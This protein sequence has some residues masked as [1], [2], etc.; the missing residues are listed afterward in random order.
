MFLSATNLFHAHALTRSLSNSPETMLTTLALVYFPLPPPTPT[1]DPLLGGR[2]SSE[3][4][5]LVSD[6]SSQDSSLGRK[7]DEPKPAISVEDLDYVAMDRGGPSF[8]DET[9]VPYIDPITNPL[10]FVR[11][12]P[13]RSSSPVSVFVCDLPPSCSGS[14]SVQSICSD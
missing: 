7:E 11:A 13:W 12:S 6:P 1:S 3:S 4:I 10:V 8:D 2:R 9:Y 14:T 5:A